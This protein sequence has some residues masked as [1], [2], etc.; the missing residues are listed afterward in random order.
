MADEMTLQSGKR[1]ARAF[2]TGGVC[3]LVLTAAML[4]WASAT[5][6]KIGSG[7][8]SAGRSRAIVTISDAPTDIKPLLWKMAGNSLIRPAQV[9]A[10]VKDKGAAQT[11]AK[12][13]KL[14]GVVQMAGAFTAYVRIDKN[15]QKV[16]EGDK[17]LEFVV[18]K[19]QPGKVTLNLDGVEVIL[20]H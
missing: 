20:G 10:A 14:Q 7:T 18:S 3:V 16:S 4:V 2:L 13:L 9:Q 19:I 12:R 1:L 6:L 11:L 8:Q 5:P 17:I 15:T